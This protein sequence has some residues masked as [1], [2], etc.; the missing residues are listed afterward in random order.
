MS[1][2]WISEDPA[3]LVAQGLAGLVAQTDRFVLALSGGSTPQTLYRMLSGEFR[4]R[5]PWERVVI[6]QVDERCVPPDHADSNWRMLRETLLAPLPEVRAHRIEAERPGAAED[7][8]SLIRAEVPAGETGIPRLDL[9]LLGLGTDGHTAS[10]F[11]GTPALDESCRLVVSN[12][13]PTP[14]SRRV[15]MTYPLLE[16]AARRWFLV[17]GADKAETLAR[18]REGELPAGRLSD[19]DWFLDPAAAG[20]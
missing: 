12:D 13:G 1:K 3:L 20:D 7:Y 5:I 2:T 10:L 6:L 8:E 16:A 19:A 18:V 9:A 4:R 17:T 14:G 11:P 15:T